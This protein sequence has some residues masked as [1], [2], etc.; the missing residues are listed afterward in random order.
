MM[1]HLCWHIALLTQLLCLLTVEQMS[2]LILNTNKLYKQFFCFDREQGFS[3]VSEAVGADHRGADKSSHK[4]SL[5]K[6]MV[7]VKVDT[8]HLLLPSPPSGHVTLHVQELW[9][10]LNYCDCPAVCLNFRMKY[11]PSW[12]LFIFSAIVMRKC[13]RASHLHLNIM[14]TLLMKNVDVVLAEVCLELIQTFILCYSVTTKS[15]CQVHT[16]TK[17]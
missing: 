5:L 3:S 4:Q 6:E 11:G 12:W 9:W 1:V 14:G 8:Q 10:I 16:D 7:H 13:W 17:V 15:V 2:F